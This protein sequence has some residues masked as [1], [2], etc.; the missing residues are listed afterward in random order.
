ML[1]QTLVYKF[2]CGHIFEIFSSSY[3]GVGLLRHT[4]TPCLTFKELPNGFPQRLHHSTF[5]PAVYAASD[6]STFSPTLVTIHFL[7]MA[8]LLNVQ[9]CLIVVSNC[10]S[11]MTN[12]VEHCFMCFLDIWMYSWENYL[13]TSFAPFYFGCLFI[14][15]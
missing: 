15:L 9:W 4:L 14:E 3:L 5:P 11:L 10:I 13:F 7:N 8:I 1:L 6:Y 2:L 12:E